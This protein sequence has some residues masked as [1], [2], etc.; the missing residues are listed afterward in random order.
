MY[1]VKGSHFYMT[2]FLLGTPHGPKCKSP[3]HRIQLVFTTVYWLGPYYYWVG[4]LS[5]L[6]FMNEQICSMNE[7]IRAL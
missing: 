4:E 6:Q 1:I 5:G 3:F 2:D 7:Q